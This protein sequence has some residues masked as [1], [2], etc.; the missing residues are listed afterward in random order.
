MIP[1]KEIEDATRR[2]NV[3]LTYDE[4]GFEEGT[5]GLT[6]MWESGNELID[7]IMND[8][9]RFGDNPCNKKN[10]LWI[11]KFKEICNY[12]QGEELF[13]T[14]KQQGDGYF[15]VFKAE[16]EDFMYG[17]KI[18]KNG[19]AELFDFIPQ[20]IARPPTG[21]IMNS[22]YNDKQSQNKVMIIKKKPKKLKIVK[23]L[24]KN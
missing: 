8:E 6:V 9:I 24:N 11:E 20:Y 18:H 3:L 5:K 22:V 13:F 4:S 19:Y 15:N 2:I 1:Q 7:N 12:K 17:F 16:K 14:T 21:I 23:T 10:L